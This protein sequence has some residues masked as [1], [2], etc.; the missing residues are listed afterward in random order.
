MGI[1]ISLFTDSF[2]L[3]SMKMVCFFLFQ[4]PRK[5]KDL[6]MDEKGTT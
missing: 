2:L 3:L 1:Y 6:W 4:L 5:A